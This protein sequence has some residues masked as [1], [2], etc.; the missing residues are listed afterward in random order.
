MEYW[1]SLKSDEGARFDREVRLDASAIAPQVSWGTSPQDVLP[2][3]GSVPDPAAESDAGRRQAMQRALEEVT[4]D[5]V[6]HEQ[7]R[8]IEQVKKR[9]LPPERHP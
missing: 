9:C 2:I 3:T 4:G 5:L 1:R 6:Q 8:F 7:N